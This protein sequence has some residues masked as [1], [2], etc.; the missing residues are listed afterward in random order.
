MLFG[1]LVQILRMH[2]LIERHLLGQNGVLV[3][4]QMQFAAAREKIG[5]FVSFIFS[6]DF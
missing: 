4:A 5:L 1:N 2:E 6:D 3:D